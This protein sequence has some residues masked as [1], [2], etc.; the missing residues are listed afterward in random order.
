MTLGSSWG[1]SSWPASPARSGVLGD[2][3]ARELRR[4]VLGALRDRHRDLARHRLVQPGDLP[5]RLAH[6]TGTAVVG[7]HADREAQRQRA[8]V[9][10]LVFGGEALAA[11]IAEDVFDV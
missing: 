5:V 8:E 9:V 1:E 2:L 7:L 6:D 10:H 3:N 4:E 11:F